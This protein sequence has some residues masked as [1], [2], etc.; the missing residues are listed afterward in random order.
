MTFQPF[1]P[2]SGLS[3]WTLLKSTL[4]VQKTIFN[5]STP[6]ASDS[7]YFLEKFD[8]INSP[9]DIVSDRRLLRVVLG[10]YGLSD[11]IE[12][13]FFIRKV[14]TDGVADQSALANKLADRRY[15]A[16]ARDFDFSKQPPGHKTLQGLAQKTV[17]NFQNTSFEI[18]IGKASEDMRLALG[19]ARELG[20]LQ[21]SASSSSTAWYQVLATPPLREVFQTALGLP[22]EFA[23]LD[24]DEQHKRLMDKAQTVFGSNDLLELAAEGQSEQIVRRFLLLRQVQSMSGATPL[25]T[26]LVLLSGIPRTAR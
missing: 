24:I 10:A 12:N 9:D 4:P 13:R 23:Q 6:T 16:L 14:L 15:R 11:D 26:A 25:Q 8:L 17:E 20:N 3:G 5:R 22:K 19:F 7:G 2:G 1:V 18:E 21:R